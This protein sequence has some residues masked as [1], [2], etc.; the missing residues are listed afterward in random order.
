MDLK[1][2]ALAP[3]N[4]LFEGIRGTGKTHILK[5]LRDE[6][7]AIPRRVYTDRHMNFVADALK[8]I[9]VRKEKEGILL[10]ISSCLLF[11]AKNADFQMAI[12]ISTI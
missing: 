4:I 5:M 7:L 12:D 8:N 1:Q 10:P 2:F 3:T 11:V 9:A 6:R